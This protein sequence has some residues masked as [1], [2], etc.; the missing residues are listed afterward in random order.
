MSPI[1]LFI[2]GVA[3]FFQNQMFVATRIF[4][5]I[6]HSA[7]SNIPRIYEFGAKNLLPPQHTNFRGATCFWY[8]TNH[9]LFRSQICD[10]TLLI[11]S[12]KYEANIMADLNPRL[13]FNRA[14]QE[15]LAKFGVK[16]AQKKIIKQRKRTKKC[17]NCC[18][19]SVFRR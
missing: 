18:R 8:F 10:Y 7:S 15:L 19:T 11:F 3:A 17:M 1:A 6:S 2:T 13:Q 9:Y 4:E 16:A 12:V 5:V 14:M